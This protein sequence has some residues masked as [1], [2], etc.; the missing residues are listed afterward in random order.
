MSL[1][2]IPLCIAFVAHQYRYSYVLTRAHPGS[3]LCDAMLGAN[4]VPTYDMVMA[5]Y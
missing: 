3:K 1:G 5:V 4:L 2:V